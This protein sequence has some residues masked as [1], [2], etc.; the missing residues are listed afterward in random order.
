MDEEAR[1]EMSQKEIRLGIAGLDGH[2]PVFAD[3]VNAQGLLPGVR[4]VAAMPYPSVMISAEQ[5][6]QNVERTRALGIQIVDE[7]EQLADAVDGILVLHDDGSKHLDLARLFAPF[8]KPMFVDKPFEVTAERAWGI[9]T[10]C[11][12]HSTPVFSASSLRFSRELT[13]ALADTA[14]GAITSAMTYSPYAPKPTMP[15]WIYYAVHSVEPLFQILGRGCQ[16]VACVAADSG[17]VAIGQWED[18][19]TGIAKAHQRAHWGYGFT[20]WRDQADVPGIVDAAYIY[21]AL[22][23]Q[24]RD[25]VLTGKAPVDPEESVEMVAF[26]EAANESM[27]QGGQTVILKRPA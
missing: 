5:L 9:V 20:I 25:F 13:A 24:I 12:Q 19:R 10:A 16:Q 7:P 3:V 17:P 8:G 23:A 21:P 1:A 14:G 15:G 2:G 22:L 18:G 27:A 6:A 11:R 4:V 26:M